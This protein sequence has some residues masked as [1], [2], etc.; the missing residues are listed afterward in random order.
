M[1]AARPAALRR[2]GGAPAVALLGDVDVLAAARLPTGVGELDRVLGGGLV[3]GSLVLIG[4]EP[5]VGKSSLLLQA[6]AAVA[7]AG[8]RTLLVCG[9]ESPAQVRLRAER[10]G[11]GSAIRVLADTDLDAVCEAIAAE[12]PA[13]CVVDS[14]QTPAQRRPAVGAGQR[15]PGA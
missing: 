5:G 13:V 4:G 1:R 6:L 10:L 3:P 7:A 11:A 9:E 8:G 15:R 12:A 2:S 14:V